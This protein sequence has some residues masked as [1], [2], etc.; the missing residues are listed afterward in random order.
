M[1]DFNLKKFLVENKLTT[2]S[3]FTKEGVDAELAELHSTSNITHDDG[4]EALDNT[5]MDL[6]QVIDQV[7]PGASLSKMVERQVREILIEFG[8]QMVDL[9]EKLT[10]LDLDALNNVAAEE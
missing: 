9:G 4:K 5:V 8:E 10:L 3:K 2:N 1:E 6:L 7:K